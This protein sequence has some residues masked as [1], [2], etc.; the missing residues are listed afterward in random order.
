[1]RHKADLQ[2]EIGPEA[3]KNIIKCRDYLEKKIAS[4][5]SLHYG[6]NTGFGSL[7]NEVISNED[8]SK[9]QRNLVLSHACGMG[10]FIPEKIVRLMI[11]LKVISCLM[12]TQ[13]FRNKQLTALFFYIMKKVRLWF[14]NKASRCLWRLSS[15]CPFI[16]SINR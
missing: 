16:S 2:I 13:G 4:S 10:D 8:L 6:I 15:T 5:E 3:R 11:L 14:L 12:V 7:C 1:M 9:L